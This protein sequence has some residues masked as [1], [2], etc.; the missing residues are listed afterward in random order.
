MPNKEDNKQQSLPWGLTQIAPGS[1]KSLSKSKLEA[2]DHGTCYVSPKPLSKR[3]QEELKKKQEE[4]ETASVLQDF[5]ASFD[6]KKGDKTTKMFVKGKMSNVLSKTTTTTTTKDDD[7]PNLN[8]NDDEYYYKPAFA[9]KNNETSSSANAA[10]ANYLISKEKEKIA[11]KKRNESNKKSNL[12]LFK[13]ELKRIQMERQDHRSQQQKPKQ[14]I[15]DSSP[16]KE[17]STIPTNNDEDKHKNSD[18]NSDD[19]NTTNI[20]ISNLSPKVTEADLIKRFG[21]YGP[22]ASVKIMWPRPDDDKIRSTNCGFVAFM[23]RRDASQ[24]L[25]QLDGKSS[26]RF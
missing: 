2:F 23:N 17:E 20:F 25:E 5:C 4:I 16:L 18:T 13:E 19:P 3:E 12:E 10:A 8:Q 21:D 14:Q 7:K 26:N 15:K 24:C 11:A 1:I 9:S 6:D 22:L